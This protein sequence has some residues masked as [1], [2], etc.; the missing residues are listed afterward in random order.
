MPMGKGFAINSDLDLGAMLLAGYEQH[1]LKWTTKITTTHAELPHLRIAAIINDTGANLAS[2]AYTA[3]PR[4]KNKATIGLVVGTGCNASIPLKI[5]I[6]DPSKHPIDLQLDSTVEVMVN[7]E[8]SI[9]GSAG[10][11]KRLDIITKW[12]EVLDR[13]THSPGFMPFEYMTAGHYLGELIRLCLVDWF[14]IGCRISRVKVPDD[15]CQPFATKMSTV[16]KLVA[17]STDNNALAAKLNSTR[18][19]TW[20]GE[21]GWTSE[22]AGHLRS[23]YT[24]VVR[25]SAAMVAAAIIGLLLCAGELKL[26]EA[27]DQKTGLPGDQRD[28]VVACSGGLITQCPGY[29]DQL[30]QFIDEVLASMKLTNPGTN[31]PLHEVL[32]GGI[33]GAGVFAATACHESQ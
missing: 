14:V 20:K 11:L 24:L 5:D 1:R 23:A 22:Y 33:I 25:R 10:P 29:K 17:E 16:S 21:L 9:N 31:V 26:A 18:G 28:L 19:M 13:S 30:Q 27:D 3:S 12:D 7:T 8:W 6:L 32:D 2:I 15:L 4:K